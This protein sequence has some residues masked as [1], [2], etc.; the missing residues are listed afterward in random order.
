MVIHQTGQQGGE[1]FGFQRVEQFTAAIGD[2]GN[3]HCLESRFKHVNFCPLGIQHG[4]I[5]VTGRARRR[6]VYDK[7]T[8]NVLNALRNPGGF[9]EA[10]GGGRA[11]RCG[12][13]IT[14]YDAIRW[15]V[16][17]IVR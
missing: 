17:A 11:W 10:L 1:V 13:R 6:I 12:E 8:H 9:M 5:T 16:R 7:L 2:K 4:D 15:G 3:A 14:Q